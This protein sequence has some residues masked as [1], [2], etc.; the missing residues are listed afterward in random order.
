MTST[1]VLGERSRAGGPGRQLLRHLG[2][3]ELAQPLFCRLR[4]DG[5]SRCRKVCWR[6]TWRRWRDHYR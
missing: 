5:S 2:G 6:R 4:A 3:H 1:C